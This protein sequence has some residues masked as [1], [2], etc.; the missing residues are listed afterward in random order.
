MW[1]NI[2]FILVIMIAIYIFKNKLYTIGKYLQYYLKFGT[3]YFFIILNTLI[4]MPLFIWN[5]K[6]VKNARLMADTS[7][8]VTKLLGV[9]WHLKNAEIVSENRG[10]VIILNHQSSLDLLGVCQ[11]WYAWKKVAIVA[12]KE[13]FYFW[14]FGLGLYLMDAIFVDRGNPKVAHELLLTKSKNALQNKIKLLIFPEG[15]RNSDFTKFLPFKKGAFNIAVGAQVPIIPI[16]ISR[17]Y[18]INHQRH[19]FNKG[20][21]IAQCL[22]PISTEGLTMDDVPDLINRVKSTMEETFKELSHEVTKDLPPDY[23]LAT[24]YVTKENSPNSRI[25]LMI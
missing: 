16:V 22:E 9:T 1:D 13:M 11:F 25:N 20:H 17:Y 4:L 19:I 10:A 2:V 7:K 18:F 8:D 15:T 21:V 14:P 6:N 3:V 5:G 23:P 24:K 12:K